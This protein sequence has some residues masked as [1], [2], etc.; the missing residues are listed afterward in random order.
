MNQGHR[1]RDL[2]I[3]FLFTVA[4]AVLFSAGSASAVEKPRPGEAFLLETYHRNRAKLEKNSFGLPLFLESSE[5]NDRVHV[6][7]YGIFDYPFSNVVNVLK[8]PANWCDIVS[9]HPNIK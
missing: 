1:N 5:L 8:L 3:I 2:P 9:L 4:V 7:V 6:D